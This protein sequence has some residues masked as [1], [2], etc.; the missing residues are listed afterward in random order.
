MITFS[1]AQI[2]AW[3]SPVLWPFL[4]T[5]AV[6][7]SAPILSSRALPVRVR[8]GLSFLV[9]LCAQ[10]ALPDQPQVS[11]IGPLALET[12]VQQVGVGLSIGFAVR[13]VFA[14]VG[15]V[16]EIVGLQMGLNFAS[17][18]DPT[19]NTQASATSGFYNQMASL[20]FVVMNGHLLILMAVVQSFSAFPVGSGLLDMLNKVRLFDMG[21]GLF[22]SALWIAL[23]MTGALMLVNLGMGI[24]SRVA[25]QMNIYAI[26]FPITLIVGLVGITVT[27]P[28][29]EHPVTGL[30]EKAL[31]MFTR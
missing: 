30:F 18:F 8:V 19:S 21:A 28:M 7:S 2:V 15:M 14:S 29:L 12:L 1:E 13:V 9:A 26:G 23:P 27:L 6:F 11:F 31:E 24:I 10:A 16:G 5:L 20:L 4:R 17:F 25:P 3:V 22:S